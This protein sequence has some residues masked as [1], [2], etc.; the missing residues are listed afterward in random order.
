MQLKKIARYCLKS[1]RVKYSGCDFWN[2]IPVFCLIQK[3]TVKIAAHSGM[4][5][6]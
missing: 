3:V 4:P 2:E 1:A 6:S 5:P